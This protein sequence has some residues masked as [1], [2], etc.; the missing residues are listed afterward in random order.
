M[1]L[2]QFGQRS[3]VGRRFG[4]DRAAAVFNGG[5]RIEQV[6]QAF[7]RNARHRIALGRPAR[8]GAGNQHGKDSHGLA[9]HGIS[10][11][12]GAATLA[13]R[14]ACGTDV[15]ACRPVDRRDPHNRDRTMATWRRSCTA[16]GHA[17][18]CMSGSSL[19]RRKEKAG[20]S[21]LFHFSDSRSVST[22]VDTHQGNSDSR[23]HP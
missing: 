11:F 17:A 21:P 2:L 1:R 15:A 19:R 3:E 14:C 5:K 18:T 22:K 9:Q 16:A 20:R 13:N 7:G 10:R 12:E 8:I 6:G 4:T 23:T